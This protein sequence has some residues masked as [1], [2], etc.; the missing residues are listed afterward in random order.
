MEFRSFLQRLILIPAQIALHARSLTVR[1]F[2]WRPEFRFGS[3]AK[4]RR[5][6]RAM[7]FTNLVS[8]WIQSE[9]TAREQGRD[10]SALQRGVVPTS[11][12]AATPLIRLR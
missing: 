4:P 12:C 8:V 3:K 10:G 11:R 2:A 5:E 7:A 6:K 9:T 1:S